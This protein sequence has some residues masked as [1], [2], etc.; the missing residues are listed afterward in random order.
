MTADNNSDKEASQTNA[1]DV[2]WEQNRIPGSEEPRM[3]LKRLKGLEE[4]PDF[5][6]RM[7]SD[8]DPIQM[9]KEWDSMGRGIILHYVRDIKN[10]FDAINNSTFNSFV[11]SVI[12]NP[13]G[14]SLEQKNG[15][16]WWQ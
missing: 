15:F 1:F 4:I 2:F 12:K 5:A 10:P 11:A 9:F 13:E 3:Y 6:V 8:S 16:C 14:W 7:T